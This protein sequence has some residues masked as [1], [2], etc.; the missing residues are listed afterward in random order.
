MSTFLN[1][2]Q[3]SLNSLSKVQ[4][5]AHTYDSLWKKRT[6]EP[7]S[8]S[9]CLSG[10][11]AF[12]DRLA[13]QGGSSGHHLP[14]AH[15][16]K[17]PHPARLPHH[18]IVSS[19][20]PQPAPR[21]SPHPHPPPRGVQRRVVLFLM[22]WHDGR[23]LYRCPTGRPKVSLQN[24]FSFTHAGTS[25]SCLDPTNP[26]ALPSI[27]T[28]T[29]M[30]QTHTHNKPCCFLP[31]VLLGKCSLVLFSV[32]GSVELNRRLIFVLSS[33]FVCFTEKASGQRL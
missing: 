33:G 10:C 24:P 32:F 6:F 15:L 22:P 16:R 7:L 8:L 17:K 19:V 3:D 11:E 27:R 31:S 5:H 21:T 12:W 14:A 26:T 30:L 20:T 9:L 13:G 1:P 28:N 25:T 4:Q 18:P 2:I 29:Y 23:T